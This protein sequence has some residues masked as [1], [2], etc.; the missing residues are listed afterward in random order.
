M[1]ANWLENE[2]NIYF[3]IPTFPHA[4]ISNPLLIKY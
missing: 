2:I 3:F 1:A 4:S